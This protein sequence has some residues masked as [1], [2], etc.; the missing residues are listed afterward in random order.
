MSKRFK[1]L[2]YALRTLQTPTG[3]SDNDP[4]AG[5]VLEEYQ[6]FKLGKKDITYTRA[7]TS[8]P[9][10]FDNVS[11]EPF[12]YPITT[13]HTI[14]PASNRALTNTTLNAVITACGIGNPPNGNATALFDFTP[15]RVTVFIPSGGAA[16]QPEPSQITG[17][18]Y[19]KRGG[20]SWTLP[21]GQRTGKTNESEV[22]AD[23]RAA[24]PG[25]SNWTISFNSEEL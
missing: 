9:G 15:A 24:A 18:R 17:I 5:S 6:R 4:P 16:P 23:I 7:E 2:E 10:A 11:I 20:N 12:G 19:R 8:N 25:G 14:V 13:Q 21:Y 1:R 22:R 3:S